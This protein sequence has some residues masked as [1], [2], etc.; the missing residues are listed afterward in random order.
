MKKIILFTALISLVLSSCK[1][2][3]VENEKEKKPIISL[4]AFW[5]VKTLKSQNYYDGMLQT[6]TTTD[7]TADQA[8]FHF[9]VGG[10]LSLTRLYGWVDFK[11]TYN[12]TTKE[13]KLTPNIIGDATVVMRVKEL[14]DTKLVLVLELTN[15]QDSRR[16][17]ISE[18]TCDEAIDFSK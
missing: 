7:Y 18:Y 8:Y 1:K 13:I 17:T 11:Y 12:E 16:R 14:T 9:L 3:E 5:K 15:R 10:D 6:E 2:S 4:I